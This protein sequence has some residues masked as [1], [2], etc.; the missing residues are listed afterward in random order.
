[1]AH[2]EAVERLETPV[3][4]ARRG[5][6]GLRPR[7]T[8]STGS[9]P[10]RSP[11]PSCSRCSTA[12]STWRR[13][14][15]GSVR[16]TGV[17]AVAAGSI[18][19]VEAYSPEPGCVVQR[20]PGAAVVSGCLAASSTAVALDAALEP[21]RVPGIE[22]RRSATTSAAVLWEKAARLA[23]LAAATVASGRAVGAL[24]ADAAWRARLEAALGEACA[25]AAADGV[26]AR[27][28]RPMGDHRGHA[29]R[30]HDVGRARRRV[31]ATR[32]SWTRSR[33]PSSAPARGSACRRRRSHGFSRRRHAERDSADRRARGLGARAG[34]ERPPARGSPAARL[35]DRDGAAVGGLRPD[36]RLDRQRANRAGRPVVRRRRP[37]PPPGGVLD[38]DVAGHRVDR[39]DAAAARGALRPVRDRARDEPLPRPGRRSDAGSSSC[40]RRPRP[41]RSAPSSA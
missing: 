5:G 26:R 23:V 2:P 21:L 6:Q 16:A 10:R 31:R 37:V 9:H 15:S 17:T 14:A 29:R 3:G 32:P 8:R 36:R 39:V 38:L 19:R 33:A 40:S 18:G 41:T 25:V 27:R 12:S 24:R 30:S 4:A 1:M 20:T 7:A 28:S 34:Q 22:R 35:R 11:T 13:F